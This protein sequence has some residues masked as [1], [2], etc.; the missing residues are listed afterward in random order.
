MGRLQR[1]RPLLGTF[2]EIGVEADAPDVEL[3]RM[4]DAG[5]AELEQAQARWS[6]QSTDS[7]LTRLNAAGGQVLRV[8]RRTVRLLRLARAMTAHSGGLFD[9][10]VG[11]TLVEAGAL[12]DH[13]GAPALPRGEAG[14]IE[15]GEGWARLKRAVRLTLDGIAKGFA[16]DLAVSALRRQGAAAGWVNAGGDLR[17]F[18]EL[19]LPVSRREADGRLTP[20]GG[21]RCGALASSGVRLGEPERFPALLVGRGA[22]RLPRGVHSV[23]ARSAWR[24]DA[25]TKVAAAAPARERAARVRALGGC[26]IENLEAQA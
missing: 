8:H 21:L 6:F 4:I 9:C 16:V 26:L 5:F 14:D 2:V 7:E 13:G 22:R 12:P 19:V 17:V 24:A 11:G 3:A 15:I 25:L 1:M 20:L 10:T 23:I 18:G